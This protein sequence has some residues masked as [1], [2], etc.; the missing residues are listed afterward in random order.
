M[1]RHAVLDPELSVRILAERPLLYN[2]AADPRDDRPSH[3][4]AASGI[5]VHG[6]R[7]VVVQ[8]D[9]SF[10]AIITSDGVSASKLPRGLDGRRRFEVAL[11]NKL[12]K[13]DLESCVAI[14]DEL[15]AF[16]SGSL[17]IRDKICVVQHGVIRVRD[18]APLYRRI[19]E[20]L[21]SACN[22]EG[23]ARVVDELWLFHRGNTGPDDV[24]PAVVRIELAAMRAWLAAEAA[25]P[26]IVAVDGYDLG[27]IEGASLGFTDAIAD[28][29]RVFYLATA[30]L[31]PNAVDDGR[32]VGSQLGVIDRYSVRAA[33]V[34]GASGAPIKAEGIALDR[35][36][37]GR[38]WIALDPDDPD[39]P[40]VL[41]DVELVGPW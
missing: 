8:D 39:E 16:G 33:P 37:P 24:G 13:L 26:P 34:A 3:V 12:D 36:R 10:L 27:S 14:D 41:L 18:A 32:V 6:G 4:R 2:E 1:S 28:K 5:A 9:A 7:L 19:R 22:L 25:L 30:E 20:Q 35:S 17:P 40:A 23:A 31:S 21:G 11:G 38:A 29:E 15:W